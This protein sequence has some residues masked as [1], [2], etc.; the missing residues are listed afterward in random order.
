MNLSGMFSIGSQVLD[1]FVHGVMR[2][3]VLF[4]FS[5]AH[6]WQNRS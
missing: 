5:T 2:L 1:S 4:E 3:E 6:V